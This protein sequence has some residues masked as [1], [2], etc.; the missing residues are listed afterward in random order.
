A[1]YPSTN[2]YMY[3]TYEDICLLLSGLHVGREEGVDLADRSPDP[4]ECAPALEQLHVLLGVKAEAQLHPG[5][6]VV[7]GEPH[8]HG[9]VRH[10]GVRRSVL[11]GESVGER[12]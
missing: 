5:P 1:M 3:S 9:C 8:L 7:L 4:I 10:L 2:I 12:E 6:A 11:V